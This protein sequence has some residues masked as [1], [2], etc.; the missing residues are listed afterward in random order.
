MRRINSHPILCDIQNRET[1]EI[2]FNGQKIKAYRGETIAAALLANGI[3]V[4]GKS[5]RFQNERG[6]FCG[7]GQCTECAMIV[8]GKPNVR[9]CVT[10]VEEN[11]SVEPQYGRGKL[12]SDEQC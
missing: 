2:K 9:T 5:P 3:D 8:N 4:L 11:M 10:E 7:I 1:V 6:L 12:N